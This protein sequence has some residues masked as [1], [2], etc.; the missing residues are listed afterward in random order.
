[1][2]VGAFGT[3]EGRRPK[4]ALLIGGQMFA[5]MSRPR[6]GSQESGFT[7]IEAM[8]TVGIVAIL[9][10][11]AIP[12]YSKY[13]LRSDLTEAPGNLASFRTTLEQFYQDNR[14]YAAGAACGVAAPTG[15]Y[16]TYTCAPNTAGQ[17]YVATAT[18]AAGTPA[19]GYVYTLNQLNVQATTAVGAHAACAVNATA[20]VTK[21]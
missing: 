15:T 9:A 20:W 14:T 10:A 19:A 6:G 8:I 2:D 7:L 16:F 12:S 13:V 4:L 11:I 3:H 21:C 5:D 18:G 17:G 1:M